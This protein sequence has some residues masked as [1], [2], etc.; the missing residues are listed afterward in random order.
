M[1]IKCPKCHARFRRS[2][3]HPKTVVRFGSFYRSSDRKHVQRLY[4]KLCRYHFSVATLSPHYRQKKRQINHFVARLYV[5]LISQRECARVLKINRKTATR[6][7]VHMGVLAQHK[8]DALNK[9]RAHL[10]GIVEFDDMETF[11]HTKCKPLSIPLAV[12]H[13]SRWILGFEVAEMPANGPLAAISRKKY[14]IR[15]DMRVA[16]R[17]RLFERIKPYLKSDAI[18]K[19]DQ[20][21]HYPR[22][23]KKW[24][25]EAKHVAYKGRRGC[26]V[27]QGELKKIGFDPLFSLNH[28]CA[29]FRARASRLIR[30]TWCT[31]KKPERLR[32]HLALVALQHNLRLQLSTA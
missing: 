26:I 13:K 7:I 20:N 15:K 27:G 6:K 32:L 12:E 9:K 23:V 29:T 22:D 19:S 4:C 8:L 14:G 30:R 18:I 25:P 10:V 2:D 21:P 11:E 24:F 16:A 5:A 3:K 1:K 17:A 28:T 31:T